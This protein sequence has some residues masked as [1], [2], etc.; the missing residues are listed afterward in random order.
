MPP[1]PSPR[2]LFPQSI[3]GFTVQ[4]GGNIPTMPTRFGVGSNEIVLWVIGNTS[5]QLV[6]V[7]LMNFV[8]NGVAVT[9][10]VWLV[11][12][13]VAIE[14]DKTGFIAGA[15]NIGGYSHQNLVDRVKYTIR[16]AGAFPMV[17]YDP[18]G[19]IKP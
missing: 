8:R 12:D 6:T 5:G 16:V 13:N 14:P 7:R 9:P 19:D 3:V 2:A 15:K 17:D 4:A 18:D 10:F 1:G 11:D